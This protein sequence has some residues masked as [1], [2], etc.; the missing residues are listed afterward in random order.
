MAA[1]ARTTKRIIIVFQTPPR[2]HGARSATLFA[3]GKG[4]GLG[5]FVLRGCTG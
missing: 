3:L 2:F 4:K 5:N 1:R